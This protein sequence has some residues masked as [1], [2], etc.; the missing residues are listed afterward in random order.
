MLR[1]LLVVAAAA[2]AAAAAGCLA[3]SLVSEDAI[4]AVAVSNSINS[5]PILIAFLQQQ[6]Q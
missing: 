4:A 3:R 5:N 2:A 6:P 1:L